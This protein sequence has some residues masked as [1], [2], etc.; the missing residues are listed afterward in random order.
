MKRSSLETF[1]AVARLRHFRK[2]AEHLN[3]T[4]ST[5]S[6]RIADLEAYLGIQLFKRDTM[7]VSLTGI[8]RE[9][10]SRAEAVLASMDQFVS[11]AGRDPDR[12]GTLRLALSETLAVTLL[13]PFIELFAQSYPKVT[14]DLTVDST[15]N[16]RRLLLDRA[17]DLALLLGPISDP[18]VTNKVLL[19]LP[20]V[21]AVGPSHPAAGRGRISVSELNDGP[22]I[23]Y[24]RASRPYMELQAALK[25]A[26]YP[27]PRL[28]SSNSLGA[29][30]GMTRAGMAIGTFPEVFARPYLRAGDIVR[31]EV[32]IPLQRQIYT[33][34]YLEDTA[35]R[36]IENAIELACLAACVDDFELIEKND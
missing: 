26:G 14:I 27:R 19:S 18:G 21:W 13:P 28:I 8:G 23:T 20:M 17:V 3:T 35:S 16:Q 10:I 1:L 2:A 7:G 29:T 6:A 15:A 25:A 31:V 34:S 12:E 30:L 36:L 5:V 33:I 22:I 4:Q 11:T 24:V 32:D 9:L